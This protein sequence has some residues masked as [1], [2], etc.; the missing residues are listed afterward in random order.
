[1]LP[2]HNVN[3]T[4]CC[5]SAHNLWR[6]RR[7]RRPQRSQRRH[8][9]PTRRCVG[10]AFAAIRAQRP[11]SQSRAV[12]TRMA[13]CASRAMCNPPAADRARSLHR[14]RSA[15]RV[16]RLAPEDRPVTAASSR[17]LLVVDQEEDHWEDH[18]ASSR[19]LLVVVDAAAD[20]ERLAQRA[21]LV[22]DVPVEGAAVRLDV[23]A[24]QRLF[25]RLESVAQLP[26]LVEHVAQ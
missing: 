24:L 9:V 15:A 21:H 5:R 2:R 16:P 4:F 18:Y 26:L 22:H 8:L 10:H 13:S 25:I 17:H 11:Q 3:V 19:H 12:N 7:Y 6:S 1:M 23:A 14:A 20:T